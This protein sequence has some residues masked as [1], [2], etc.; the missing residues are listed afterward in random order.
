MGSFL[1]GMFVGST[2][3]ALLM[4]LLIASKELEQ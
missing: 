2:I 3:S 1:A 4:A